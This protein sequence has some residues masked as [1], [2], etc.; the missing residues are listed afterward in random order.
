MYVVSYFKN[1]PV[2]VRKQRG[3][4][5]LELAECCGRGNLWSRLR[6]EKS[7]RES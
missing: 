1:A 4:N 2:G 5:A 3:E 6:R 7:G